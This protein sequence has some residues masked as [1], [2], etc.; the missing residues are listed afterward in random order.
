M[1]GAPGDQAPRQ[2]RRVAQPLLEPDPVHAVA[3]AIDVAAQQPL[4][5]LHQF[6]RLAGDAGANRAGEAPVAPQATDIGRV[7][8]HRFDQL[9]PRLRP[10]PGVERDGDA[11]L[12]QSFERALDE[13]LGAAVGRV[14][15]ADDRQPHRDIPSV[16]ANSSNSAAR[17]RSTGS[18]VRHSETLPPPQPSLPQGRQGCAAEVTTRCGHQPRPPFDLAAG[19]EQRH[20]R[21]L[22]GRGDVHRRRIDADERARLA[23]QCRQLAQAERAGEIDHLF[24]RR[25][26]QPIHDGGHQA[27]LVRR[28]VRR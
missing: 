22:H 12:E 17:T 18:V 5:R 9:Q 23:R 13:A 24:S 4:V 21:C 20:D 3:G 19:P 28:R 14:A 1:I 25:W 15:L 2:R 10:A 6:R 16:S 7:A 11:A 8:Q 26:R 27:L